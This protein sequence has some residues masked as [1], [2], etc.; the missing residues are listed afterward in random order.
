[1]TCQ[2]SIFHLT[3]SSSQSK[4]LSKAKT[5]SVNRKEIQ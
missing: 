2:I 4:F 1:M 3:F 5:S